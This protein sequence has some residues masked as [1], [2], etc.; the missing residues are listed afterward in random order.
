MTI[1]LGMSL[2]LNAYLITEEAPTFKA[3]VVSVFEKVKAFFK[4]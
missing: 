1:L 2:G 3:K 4:K